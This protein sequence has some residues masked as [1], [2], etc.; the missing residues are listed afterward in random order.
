M[1][2]KSQKIAY[3]SV[4][5]TGEDV[6]KN[7]IWELSIKVADNS[8]NEISNFERVIKPTK[9][10]NETFW[11]NKLQKT[12]IEN[13]KPFS[14]F[15]ETILDVLK[16]VEI[17]VCYKQ[18]YLHFL[19]EEFMRLGFKLQDLTFAKANVFSLKTFWEKSEPRELEN[20]TIKWFGLGLDYCDSASE[21]CQHLLP[22]M[23][24]S[25]Q[26]LYNSETYE[27]LLIT[28]TEFKILDV[29]G[30]FKQDIKTNSI[31]FAKGK[32]IDKN[33]I[34]VLKNDFQYFN[35]MLGCGIDMSIHTKEIVKFFINKFS[36]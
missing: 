14:F 1:F 3:I 22:S 33:V 30:F 27:D 23:T 8:G 5:V 34:E 12:L 32:H 29:S 19:N 16:G 10:E 28:S 7:S 26:H 31:Y 35:W 24:H 9:I 25:F 15:A 4:E 11:D 18:S 6:H 17:L 36:K 21:I 13:S 20:A 2:F